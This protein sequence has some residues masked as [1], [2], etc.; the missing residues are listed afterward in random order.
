MMKLPRSVLLS[1]RKVII[2]T[3]IT[4]AS[5]LLGVFIL[6]YFVGIKPC[7]LCITQR[8][9]HA[10][11]LMLSL[12]AL[13]PIMAKFRRPILAL[14][15]LAFATTASVGAYHLSIEFGWVTGPATCSGNITG[16]T[17]EELRRQLM[18]QPFTKCN[19]I[20]WSLFGVSLAGYNFFISTVL[21]IVCGTSIILNF[22]RAKK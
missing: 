7:S 8:W 16:D 11:V 14:I 2:V 3:A 22:Q 5:L 15:S 13:L 18:A 19:D 17:V 6:Q 4:S 20:A 10:L 9:P 21:T 12:C 1:P